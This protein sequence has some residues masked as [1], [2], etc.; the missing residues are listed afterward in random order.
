MCALGFTFAVVYD[1]S[2]GSS[3]DVSPAR[4]GGGAGGTVATESATH[5]RMRRRRSKFK[6]GGSGEHSAAFISPPREPRVS[7]LSCTVSLD[8]ATHDESGALFL[9][10]GAEALSS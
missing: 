1:D 10:T 5:G 3:R 8:D 2:D 7:T 4:R 6:R 9:H